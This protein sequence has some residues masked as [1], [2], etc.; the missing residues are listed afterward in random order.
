MPQRRSDVNYRA[1]E[2]TKTKSE[3]R[4]RCDVR[5]VFGPFIPLTCLLLS[6]LWHFDSGAYP[7]HDLGARCGH[8]RSPAILCAERSL[9]CQHV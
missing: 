1:E 8:A 3:V 4:C 7:R 6:W 2:W 5:A 9:M